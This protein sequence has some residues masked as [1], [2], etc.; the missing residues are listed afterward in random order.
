MIFAQTNHLGRRLIPLLDFVQN[1]NL[2]FLSNQ[3]CL[4]LCPGEESKSKQCQPINSSGQ[5]EHWST[6]AF[7]LKR[8]WFAQ[9]GSC[10]QIGETEKILSLIVISPLLVELAIFTP[11][12]LHLRFGSNF[13]FLGVF[14]WQKWFT[15]FPFLR[16]KLAVTTLRM[17]SLWYQRFD[18]EDWIGHDLWAGL[19]GLWGEDD[20]G[21]YRE[22]DSPAAD[23]LFSFFKD[24]FLPFSENSCYA[25]DG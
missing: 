25:T 9:K 4:C 19:I 13:C 22:G 17:T 18:E 1:T 7:G 20:W 21:D 5:Q 23:L 2:T 15:M 16:Q 12:S 10:H 6:F 3:H 24:I 14:F 11:I 8:Q